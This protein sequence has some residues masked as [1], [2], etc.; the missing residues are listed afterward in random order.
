MAWLRAKQRDKTYNRFSPNSPN[1][2]FYS[3]QQQGVNSPPT[4]DSGTPHHPGKNLNHIRRIAIPLSVPQFTYISFATFFSGL[5][6]ELQS[7]KLSVGQQW[8]RAWL[9]RHPFQEDKREDTL[10]CD[11]FSDIKLRGGNV[12][13]TELWGIHKQCDITQSDNSSDLVAHIV[14]HWQDM[15]SK[16]G[17]EKKIKILKNQSLLK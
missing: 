12:E 16:D 5:P 7:S 9:Q 10:M 11:T 17:N 1:L 8:L 3:S 6:T 14:A 15:P 13:V 4:V 2:S